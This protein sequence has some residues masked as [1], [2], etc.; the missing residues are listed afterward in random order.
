MDGKGLLKFH[1]TL[2]QLVISTVSVTHL[3]GYGGPSGRVL[4]TRKPKNTEP[5]HVFAE[6]SADSLTFCST[7]RAVFW[8]IWRRSRLLTLRLYR[9][10]AAKAKAYKCGEMS[11]DSF[12]SN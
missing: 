5:E 4:Q 8:T 2:F 12:G 10:F 6:P 7:A 1:L 9:L 11:S 3:V